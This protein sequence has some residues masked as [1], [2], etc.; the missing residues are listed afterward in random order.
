[1]YFEYNYRRLNR[2]QAMLLNLHLT[3]PLI[4]REQSVERDDDLNN[5]QNER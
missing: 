2:L 4:G 1:M 5:D 3:K